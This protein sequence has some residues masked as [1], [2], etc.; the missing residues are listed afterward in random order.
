MSYTYNLGTHYVKTNTTG[1]ANLKLCLE[2]GCFEGA[3]S[4]Y[5]VD[6]LLSEDGKLICIDP[7]L[8][9]YL[10]TNLTEKDIENNKTIY[11][12]F[13]KQYER[14]IE[15]TKHQPRLELYRT[16][17]V[18]AFPDLIEKYKGQVDLIYIDGDHRAPAVYLDAVNSF[19]LCKTGG[20]IILDDYPWGKEYG[21]EAPKF[22]IDKFMEEYVGQ[23]TLVSMGW[24]VVIRK[25]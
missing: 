16:T 19:V 15:N 22:A 5:I 2:I 17:S 20:I 14:F 24:Q 11:K 6:N 7:L 25:T 13:N 12:Q 1:M 18:E 8:D 3:T 4:N 10:V 21:N 9:D 23:F